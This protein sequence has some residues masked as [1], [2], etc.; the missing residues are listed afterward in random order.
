MTE[1]VKTP[2]IDYLP[3]LLTAA[4]VAVPA[5]ILKKLVGR[6]VPVS[7]LFYAI[8]IGLL[9]KVVHDE[10]VTNTFSWQNGKSNG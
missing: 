5:I 9:V 10:V 2:V 4:A 8:I 6:T 1:K 3:G 7:E